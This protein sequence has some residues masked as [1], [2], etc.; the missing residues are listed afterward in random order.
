M[1]LM[2][3]SWVGMGTAYASTEWQ[4][5]AFYVTAAPGVVLGGLASYLLRDC[6]TRL[7]GWKYDEDVVATS[8]TIQSAYQMSFR[9]I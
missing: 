9:R 8:V 1:A 7:R 2:V 4:M 3:L 6:Y 5:Q